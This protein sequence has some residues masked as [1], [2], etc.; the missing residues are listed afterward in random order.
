MRKN[1]LFIFLIILFQCIG[2]GIL[3][4]SLNFNDLFYE[5]GWSELKHTKV[6]FQDF[7]P[8]EINNYSKTGNRKSYD[9]VLK[10]TTH[11]NNSL[12]IRMNISLEGYIA[13]QDK[14]GYNN[15][16]QTF[17]VFGVKTFGRNYTKLIDIMKQTKALRYTN[18]GDILLIYHSGNI[19]FPYTIQNITQKSTLTKQQDGNRLNKNSFLLGVVV[20]MFIASLFLLYAYFKSKQHK[21]T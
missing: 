3:S 11:E 20:F 17:E 19:T 10:V 21:N 18:K 6:R 5:M 14:E 12:E 4:E 13:L 16:E 7:E 8:K 2:I 1:D 15:I 9:A